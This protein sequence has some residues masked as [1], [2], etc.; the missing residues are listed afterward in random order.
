MKKILILFNFLIICQLGIISQVEDVHSTGLK[1]ND[2]Q[3]KTVPRKATLTRS[4][5]GASLPT[6]ASLKKYAPTPLSQGLYGTCVG[7]STAFC[8]FTIATA[9]ANGWTDK[10]VIDANTF[11]PGFVYNQAK[12]S[13]DVNCSYGT[14]IPDVLDLM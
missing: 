8:A 7:W 12:S 13:S 5:Y 6:S 10:A 3:Y 4:L 9:K 11:S 1:F 2:D 14:Y